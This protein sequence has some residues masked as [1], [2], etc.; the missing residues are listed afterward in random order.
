[1]H[2]YFSGT[3]HPVPEYTNPAEFLLDLI[4]VD[5]AK[6]KS[7]SRSRVDSIHTS[8]SDSSNSATIRSRV[9]KPNPSEKSTLHVPPKKQNTLLA[10]VVLLHRSFIKSY[11]DVIAY[12]IRLAMYTGL[13]IMMGTVWLRLS[14]NQ[15]SI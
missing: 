13:A 9:S 11:R 2:G 5:F 3:G 12:G 10:P 14:T 15:S 1:M 6:D 8:W 7:L 4:N